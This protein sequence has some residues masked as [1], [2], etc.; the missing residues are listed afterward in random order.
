M[1]SDALLSSFIPLPFT[2]TFPLMRVLLSC[3]N[4]SLTRA[5]CVTTDGELC[6]VCL[7]GSIT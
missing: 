4:L 2:H 3:D 6:T 5:A 7:G 1:H